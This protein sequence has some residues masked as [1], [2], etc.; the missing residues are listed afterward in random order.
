MIPVFNPCNHIRIIWDFLLLVIVILYLFLIPIH[1]IY[2]INYNDLIPKGI[3]VITPIVFML[4]LSFAFNTGYYEKGIYIDNRQSIINNWI[5]NILPY[6][7]ISNFP[8]IMD[9]FI[10]VFS[11]NEEHNSLGLDVVSI[12]F[13][14]NIDKLLSR[15]NKF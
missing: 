12:L 9:I 6:D 15:F 14:L 4:E 13:V 8:L 3:I 10:T 7:L 1:L 2:E 11:S 5:K